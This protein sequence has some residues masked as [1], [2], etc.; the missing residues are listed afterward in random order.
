MDKKKS[1][2]ESLEQ[3]ESN[4]ETIS[5]LLRIGIPAIMGLLLFLA[6]YR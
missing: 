4:L 2:R 3:S 5:L 6:L 1:L